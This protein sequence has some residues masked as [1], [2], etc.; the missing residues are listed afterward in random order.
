MFANYEAKSIKYMTYSTFL[1][2]FFYISIKIKSVEKLSVF[3]PILRRHVMAI[4]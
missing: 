3:S 2:V 1:F 4:L